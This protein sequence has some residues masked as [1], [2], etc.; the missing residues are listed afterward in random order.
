V[1]AVHGPRGFLAPCYEYRFLI[2]D[3]YAPWFL[4]NNQR[5]NGGH[6]SDEFGFARLQEHSKH[7]DKPYL[8]AIAFKQYSQYFAGYRPTGCGVNGIRDSIEVCKANGIRPA[9]A[10]FPESPTWLNWYDAE[11]LKELSALA[12]RLGEE[13]QVP[14]FDGRTWVPEELTM[15]GHHLSGSGA[16]LFTDRMIR[17]AVAP[18]M[19]RSRN[20]P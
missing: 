4:M 5:L 17:E 15:D 12:K 20:T 7:A 1:A 2:V 6:Q 8:L 9:L 16:D 10:F 14:V 13:Y 18:W 11:G 3:R 19:K